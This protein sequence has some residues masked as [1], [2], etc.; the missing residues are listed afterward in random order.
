MINKWVWGLCVGSS[1][2]PSQLPVADA[3]RLQLIAI[4]REWDVRKG[5][6]FA[7]GGKVID[8]DVTA[9][10]NV[11]NAA[12]GALTAIASGHPEAFSLAPAPGWKCQDNT[13]L[14][15]DATGMLGMHKAM[16]DAGVALFAYAQQLKAQVVAADDPLAVDIMAGWPSV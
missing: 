9:R 10:E 1:V 4:E 2:D 16:L 11:S 3:R 8:S 6:G 15:L 12:M 5:N 7:F 13:Y 14:A